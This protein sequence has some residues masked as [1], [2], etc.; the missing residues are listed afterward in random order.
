M[1]KSK[2]AAFKSPFNGT[3]LG[4]LI[5]AVLIIL[6]LTIHFI[7]Q[8]FQPI[9]PKLKQNYHSGWSRSLSTNIAIKANGLAVMQIDPIQKH[10]TILSVPEDSYIDMPKGYGSWKIG[11][12]YQ[13]GQEETP[14]IGAILLRDAFNT[15]LG[16]PIDQVIVYDDQELTPQQLVEQ[17]HGNRF[18][19]FGISRQAETDFTPVDLINF[20][21]SLNAIRLD[22]INYVDI[23]QND[24][25]ESR[26]LPDSTRVLGINRV[27]LDLFVREK[28][29]DQQI[30]QEALNIAIFNATTHPGL[31]QEAARIVTNLGGNVI[32][33]RNSQTPQDQS[34]VI[35]SENTGGALQHS[36]TFNR[37][38][39][40]FAPWC[41]DG[42]C[43]NNDDKVSVSRGQVTIVIGEDFYRQHH[44]RN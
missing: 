29:Q 26:L 12:I 5:I 4:L 23:G 21:Q 1:A 42:E 35:I 33:I 19:W 37:L 10:L 38:S 18:S 43:Q 24:I 16:L 7:S 2:T 34:Q 22:K 41:A 9:S 6:S 40:Y 8:L 14:Q 30:V 32:I 20:V 27:Q 11:N 39:Q 17:W 36:V 13:L 3:Y 25:T 15:L 28:M 44:E 31:A